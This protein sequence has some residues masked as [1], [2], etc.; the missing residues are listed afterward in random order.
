MIKKKKIPEYVSLKY[1]EN[2]MLS[3]ISRAPGLTKIHI[4][5]SE[6]RILA[7]NIYTKT[8]IPEENNS[9]VDG[10]AIN[11]NLNNNNKIK[12][13]GES[14]PGKPFL[15]E[16]GKNQAIRIFTGAYLLTLNNLNTVYMEEDCIEKNKFIKFKKK[17]KTGSNIR[18]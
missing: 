14:K 3:S 13:I 2:K 7:E 18:L 1:A 16:V 6:G 15:K 11:N 4:K 9:A 17:I 5:D 12:I 8:N 10:Y